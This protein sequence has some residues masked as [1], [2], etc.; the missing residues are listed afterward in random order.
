MTDPTGALR[1]IFAARPRPTDWAD[2]RARLDE[3][4][5]IDPPPRDVVFTPVDIDGIAAEL[6]QPPRVDTDLAIL[7][8]HGGGY[9]SGSI[10]SHRNMV[11]AIGRAAG[12]RVL[13]VGYR[14][15][16]EHPFPAALTDAVAGYRFLRAQGFAPQRIAIGGDSAGGGLTLAS[17]LALRAA[18]EAL[19]ACAWLVSPWVDLEMTGATIETRDGVDPLIHGTY[20][21][22]LAAAYLAGHDP[23]DPLVSPLHADLAGLPP[24]LIQ[25]GSSETLLD[26]AVR[27]AGALGAADVS[28]RLE[29]WPRMIHAFPLWPQRLADGRAAAEIAG[30]FLRARLRDADERGAA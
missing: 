15:A 12:A 10:R 11:A 1:R 17:M 29:I 9:C 18:G 19:P 3:V 28:V 24:V 27:M 14:L 4:G 8:L 16:P 20:L 7:F 13:A 30:A 5:A 22:E 25:V 6:S 2:R 21:H 26:D 23:R